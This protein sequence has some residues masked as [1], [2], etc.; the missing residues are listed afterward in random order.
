M[1]KYR[2]GP[3][4]TNLVKPIVVGAV[5]VVLASVAA[6]R[7]FFSGGTTPVDPTIEQKAA[8]IQDKVLGD[9]PKVADRVAPPPG[10]VQKSAGRGPASASP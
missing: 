3:S 10:G 4:E 1:A 5:L 9:G 2:S 6:Y 7:L 8:Q